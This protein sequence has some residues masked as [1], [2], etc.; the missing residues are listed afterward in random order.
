MKRLRIALIATLLAEVLLVPLTANGGNAWNFDQ[1]PVGQVVVADGTSRC[2]GALIGAD[3]V[4]TAAHC[5]IAPKT[6]TPVSPFDVR[7][8]LGSDQSNGRVLQ[9]RDMATPRGFFH[10][11][12]PTREQ[13]S[14]DVALLRLA[15]Q[16]PDQSDNI[17]RPNRNDRFVALL[18]ASKDAPHEGE[19]CEVSYEDNGVMVL[20]CS[21]ERGASGSPVYSMIDGER[22]LTGVVSADGTRSG[23]PV[24]FAVGPL[25]VIEDLVWLSKSGIPLPRK[26]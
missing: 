7:F 3:L 26:Y 9:V 8:T 24:L 10:S 22:R 12:V 11:E 15:A 16:V 13:I 6:S 17:A 1:A 20:A 23:E 25:D 21:R 5:V 14:T 2:T 19:P 4:L 18:P